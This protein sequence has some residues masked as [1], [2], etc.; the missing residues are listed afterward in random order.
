MRLICARVQGIGRLANVKINLDRKLVA[1][2]GPN[3][4]GKTTLLKSLE[5]ITTGSA[6][7]SKERTR[8]LGIP[9]STQ[10]VKVDFALDAT[11]RESLQKI[12]VYHFPNTVS[13]IRFADGRDAIVTMNP[14]PSRDFR[15]L[16]ALCKKFESEI[17][18]IR[19]SKKK[20]AESYQISLQNLERLLETSAQVVASV[21]ER[22]SKSTE[23]DESL[24]S[25]IDQL[26]NEWSELNPDADAISVLADVGDWLENP[27]N[28]NR[29]TK[30]LHQRC[31]DFLMFDQD[32][33]ELHSS[34]T[35]SNQLL[36]NVPSSLRNLA[37]LSGLDLEEL[38]SA[39]QENNETEYKTALNRA[40]NRLKTEFGAAWKQS[41]L[42]VQFDI[43]GTQLQIQVEENAEVITPFDQRSA[44]LR[45]F[46]ALWA[47]IKS[48]EVDTK[49][50]LLI[51]EAETHL[52]L[53]AQAD[54]IRI[55]VSQ[56]A[57]SNVIYTTHSPGCLP[58]DL[59]TGVR[60]VSQ[61]KS[62]FGHS[63]VSNNFWTQSAGFSP[64]MMAMGAA[65]SA[66]STVR[67]AVLAEGASDMLLLPS[68]LRAANNLD[69]L[70]YQVAPGLS[71]VPKQFYPDLDLTAARVV[72]LVDGDEGGQ[73]LRLRLE[74]SGV[75]SSKIIALGA[76]TLEN[77]L[78]AKQ[79]LSVFQSLLHECNPGVTVPNLPNQLDSRQAWPKQLDEWAKLQK[80]VAPSKVAVASR[81]VETN[82]A[83][84]SSD[85]KRVLRRLHSRISEALGSN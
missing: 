54:L 84:P 42:A 32:S 3:E 18:K 20:Y 82:S 67:Y 15:P 17:S 62:N 39:V 31:P 61:S 56:Q 43:E 29:V 22:E 80:L 70:A 81:L 47:F 51:D 25:T 72:Y 36:S 59:G 35:L 37:G 28:M 58:M 66:F 27:L 48:A 74:K 83:V 21:R 64:L 76:V 33:R 50:V 10:V 44:G 75:E 40:N 26:S 11:D 63:E 69:S 8:G 52:H 73:S 49:P 6:L 45:M 57:A 19:R 2:V 14:Q 12:G 60:V 65:A 4:A 16:G 78:E 30:R 5:L 53:D 1:I 55:L 79:D 34:Y 38:Y 9:D 77:S 85:G 13:I 24:I 7:E 68:L 41:E 23:A 46:V 71:E